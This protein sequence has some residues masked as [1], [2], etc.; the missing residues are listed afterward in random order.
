MAVALTAEQIVKM[1]EEKSDTYNGIRREI[2]RL[3][4]KQDDSH[5]WPISGKFN[6]TERAIRS[7]RNFESYNGIMSPLEY[8]YFLEQETSDIVNCSSNW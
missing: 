7:A 5:L 4:R 2:N 3:F 1:A 8:A 6:V